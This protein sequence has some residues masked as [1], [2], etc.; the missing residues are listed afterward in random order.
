MSTYEQYVQAA[1]GRMAEL[2]NRPNPDLDSVELAADLAIN[3]TP[4]P[5]SASCLYADPQRL[6][7]DVIRAFKERR[8]E[9]RRIR[10]RAEQ[11]QDE[12]PA[13]R[14]RIH[15]GFSDDMYEVI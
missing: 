15:A 7:N 10:H 2:L 6:Q 4:C 14:E 1:A 12:M 8:R 11:A 9:Q 5:A 13:P 3:S